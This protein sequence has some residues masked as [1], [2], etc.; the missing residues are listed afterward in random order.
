MVDNVE[1]MTLSMVGNPLYTDLTVSAEKIYLN[2]R[3][4][5]ATKCSAACRG[6]RFG[7]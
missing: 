4:K 6:F 1:K 7:T 3:Y 5:V 2:A